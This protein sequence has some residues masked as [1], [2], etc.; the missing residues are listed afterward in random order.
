MTV[1]IGEK[2]GYSYSRKKGIYKY[3]KNGKHSSNIKVVPAINMYGI[4]GV[5]KN[6]IFIFSFNKGI[7][8]ISQK[9]L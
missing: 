9:N 5:V 3:I 6:N 8:S 7:K 1:I 4:G 2:R